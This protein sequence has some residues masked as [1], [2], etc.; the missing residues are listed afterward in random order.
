MDVRLHPLEP[1]LD[2][3]SHSLK[4]VSVQP[5]AVVLHLEQHAEQRNL[6]TPVKVP[7]PVLLE[8]RRHFLGEAKGEVGV[9][10]GIGGGR[11]HRHMGEGDRLDTLPAEIG[12]LD[13]HQVEI[14]QRH[15][16][17]AV[18][19]PAR[20]DQVGGDHGVENLAADAHARLREH[21]HV[22][23]DVLPYF[24]ALIA[25]EQTAH[26]FEHISEGKLLPGFETFVPHRNIKR[27]ARLRRKTQADDLGRTGIE[28]GGFE[29]E[30]EAPRLF[31]LANHFIE[32]FFCANYVVVPSPG[33]VEGAGARRTR[34]LRALSRFIAG[35]LVHDTLEFE[36]L[37]EEFFRRRDVGPLEAIALDILLHRKV[38]SQCGELEGEAGEIGVVLEGLALLGPLDL[39]SGGEHLLETA[40]FL[41]QRYGCFLADTGDAGNVVR[42][43]AHQ[44]LDLHEFFGW[45]PPARLDL[46]RADILVFHRVPDADLI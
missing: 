18:A 15:V 44:R 43:I 14:F 8:F 39:L 23:F 7:K 31:Q 45:H 10:A 12:V 5:D 33:L 42:G 21:R 27:P 34:R 28:R 11:L 46:G 26:R 25:F 41:D 16:V 30:G 40:E 32:I 36:F 29:V 6:K 19:R 38:G 3:L 35:K 9:L 24:D 22:V 20:I 1:R 4:E 17:E 13:R 2:L 37:D